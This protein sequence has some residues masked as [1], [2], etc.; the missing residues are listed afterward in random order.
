MPTICTWSDFE[1]AISLYLRA[2]QPLEELRKAGFD[3]EGEIAETIGRTQPAA[4]QV[5][6]T[7]KH[8]SGASGP[9]AV[10]LRVGKPFP[11]FPIRPPPQY[12]GAVLVQLSAVNDIL[13]T[14]WAS[15]GIAQQYSASATAN[16]IGIDDLRNC[17]TNVRSD[18]GIGTLQLLTAPAISV[19]SIGPT[20]ARIDVGIRLNVTG[21]HPTFLSATVHADVPLQFETDLKDQQG[22]PSIG[23]DTTPKEFVKIDVVLNSPIQ[24]SS[25]QALETLEGIFAKGANLLLEGLA[26][27]PDAL[28]VPTGYIYEDKHPNPPITTNLFISKAAG[29]AFDANGVAW[30]AVGLDLNSESLGV[31]TKLVH[32]LTPHANFNFRARISEQMALGAIQAFI[33]SGEAAA[34]INRTVD[35]PVTLEITGFTLIFQDG[36]VAFTM[37]VK[38]P[39]LCFWVTDLNI[40]V[41]L[42]GPPGVVSNGIVIGAQYMDVSVDNGDAAVCIGI[43]GL[44]S[45]ITAMVE[46]LLTAQYFTGMDYNG[47]AIQST[48]SLGPLPRTQENFEVSIRQVTAEAGMLVLDGV[49][50]LA[51]DITH[52]FLYLQIVTVKG[53]GK[54]AP[55]AGAQ[56]VLYELDHPAPAGDDVRVP[57]TGT[58]KQ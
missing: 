43:S 33:D 12:P 49:G 57:Q 3:F 22:N 21:S 45:P 36:N 1:R 7:S 32:E 8:V 44:L 38:A 4:G 14:L 34:Y 2:A 6:P 5:V 52:T 39:N 18:A 37:G 17:C 41:S 11:P 58:T 55:V 29:A 24:P 25:P 40:T 28:L 26:V 19:S 16:L 13:A 54:P 48:Y 56:V 35:L 53:T 46:G 51:S 27:G 30:L 15:N 50:E 47:P 9:F 42:S 20:Y 23:I 31:P 10:R